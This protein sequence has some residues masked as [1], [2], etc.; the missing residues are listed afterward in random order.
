MSRSEISRRTALGLSG[1]FLAGCSLSRMETVPVSEVIAGRVWE[2]GHRLP[3]ANELVNSL[4]FEEQAR[5]VLAP[6]VFAGIAGSDREPFN[7]MTLRP[8]LN[9]PTLDMDLTVP[10][11]GEPLF[12][13][14]LVGPISHQRAYHAD[15]ELATI[16][17]ASAA[18][19]VTVISSRSSVPL[20]QITEATTGPL[21]YSVHADNEARLQAETAVAAG[22]RVL[23][24]TVGARPQSPGTPRW[25][26]STGR[27]DWRR[28][29]A[30][31]QGLSIPVVLHGIMT[32]A[33][34]NTAIQRGFDG[35]VV[36]DHGADG[37]VSGT[38]PV[39][40]L[41]PIVDVVGSRIPVL[42][43][44]GFRRG[45]DILKGLILG[46]DAVLLHRPVAWA[47]AS[48]GAAGV[49]RVLEKMQEEL[50]R[51]FAMI[52]ASR[53]DQLT[54]DRVRIHTRATA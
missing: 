15:G 49:Q 53:P 3:P 30:I 16:R 32:P 7:R 22:A 41:P 23:F 31:R 1:A 47:L 50:A 19:T 27:V 44:G 4:E 52:G 11:F 9:M 8:H 14:L 17:G 29:D 38:P 39:L 54:R 34:A 51:D 33:D 12:T 45:G 46:A 26:G 42:V 37:S 35:I 18:D 21:W 43:E 40:A 5:A 25:Q 36:S 6:E 48:H 24:I 10:L 2:P 28:V 20:E 13:P